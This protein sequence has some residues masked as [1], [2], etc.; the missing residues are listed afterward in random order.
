MN[1]GSPRQTDS[2]RPLA[3]YD[4]ARKRPPSPAAILIITT[5]TDRPVSRSTPLVNAARRALPTPVSSPPR[6][7]PAVESPYE[8][9]PAV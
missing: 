5:S 8:V 2:A 1:A 7:P 4:S 6:K 9:E 3:R